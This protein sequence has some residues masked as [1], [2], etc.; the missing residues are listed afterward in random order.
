MRSYL[1][2]RFVGVVFL[3]GGCA[4][5][6]GMA[7]VLRT[8]KALGDPSTYQ[9]VLPRV[10]THLIQKYGHLTGLE[11]LADHPDPHARW[12]Q[13]IH[14]CLISGIFIALLGFGL[15][16]RKEWG[17]FL[18]ATVIVVGLALVIAEIVELHSHGIPWSRLLLN[19]VGTLSAPILIGLWLAHPKTKSYFGK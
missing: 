14:R 2:V 18:A 16:T 3:I 1:I 9:E 15:L 8:H 6:L 4:I 19:R 10:R 7:N 12:R 11:D 17:R 5:A 13:Y